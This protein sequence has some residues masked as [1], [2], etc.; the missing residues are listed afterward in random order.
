MRDLRLIIEGQWWDSLLYKGQL[1]VFGMDGSLAVYAWEDLID[2]L[3]KSLGE[4][5]EALRFAF[6]ESNAVYRSSMNLEHV[7]F[8]FD[9]LRQDKFEVSAKLLE[10]YRLS[11]CSNKFPFPHASSAFHY[12]RLVVATSRGVFGSHY[13]PATQER[14]GVTR[15]TPIG[16]NQA[17]PAYGNVAVAAG[18]DG[19]F[20]VN[21]KPEDRTWPKEQEGVRLSNRACDT[22]DWMFSNIIGVSFQEGSVLARFK[23]RTLDGNVGLDPADIVTTDEGE[24]ALNTELEAEG[25]DFL[26][27]SVRGRYEAPGAHAL[28]WGSRDKIYK[29]EGPNLA[30]FRLLKAGAIKFIGKFTLPKK[31]DDIVSIRTALFGIIFE[32]DDHLIVLTSD[33]QKHEIIGEPVNWRVFPRSRRYENHLHVLRNDT[34]EIISYNNDVEQDQF[35]KL[36][37]TRAPMNWL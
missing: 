28:I 18:P 31:L 14:T 30:V 35:K 33:G 10:R 27:N 21:L 19:L 11:H 1:H 22:C 2:D 36:I 3:G 20:R 4:A 5:K 15:L 23:Q 25:V 6:A 32:Y 26:E 8:C 24:G 9:Q 17:S 13:T 34:L 12:D 37:G 7:E 16:A 29:V